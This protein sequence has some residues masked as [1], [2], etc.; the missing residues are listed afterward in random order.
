[1][2]EVWINDQSLLII[3]VIYRPS[4]SKTLDE[5]L[6]LKLLHN[7]CLIYINPPLSLLLVT[8]VILNLIGLIS[9]TTLVMTMS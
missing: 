6:I 4:D 9:N 8:S 3:G 7:D 1:M 2:C 5:M